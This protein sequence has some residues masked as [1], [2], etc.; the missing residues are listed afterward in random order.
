M[1]ATVAGF[2]A[3]MARFY[4]KPMGGKLLQTGH[5]AWAVGWHGSCCRA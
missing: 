2:V 4:G 5:R 3:G 1:G